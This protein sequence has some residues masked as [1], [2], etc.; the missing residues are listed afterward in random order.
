M[1]EDHSTRSRANFQQAQ[2]AA[3][4][5]ANAWRKH[6]C[7]VVKKSYGRAFLKKIDRDTPEPHV[8]ELMFPGTDIH[9]SPIQLVVHVD[10]S[11]ERQPIGSN[12][13]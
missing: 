7:F 2:S 3:A 11:K 9:V 10:P 1:S 12:S 13:H 8:K 4:Q 6:Q 5:L